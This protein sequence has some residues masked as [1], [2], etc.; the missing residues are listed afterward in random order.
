MSLRVYEVLENA[1]Y[2]VQSPISIQ[3]EMGIEQ[4]RN[5]L[6]QLEHNSDASEKFDEK[7]TEEDQ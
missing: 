5:A 7:Y 3:R 6:R 2:N 1:L 4:L